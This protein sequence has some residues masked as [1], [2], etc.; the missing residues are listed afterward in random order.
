MYIYKLFS[1]VSQF[2]KRSINI[3]YDCICQ[4]NKC[5]EKLYFKNAPSFLYLTIR[6][7]PLNLCTKKRGCTRISSHDSLFLY[8]TQMRRIVVY[9][10][11]LN[12]SGR[13]SAG[14]FLYLV[15]AYHIEVSLDGVLQAACSHRKLNGLLRRIVA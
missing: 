13:V 2:R 12:T 9:S 7:F 6:L 5:Q 15:Y 11:S 3:I 10:L 1:T 8:T 4:K 14:Q